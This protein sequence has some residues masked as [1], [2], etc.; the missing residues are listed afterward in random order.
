MDNLHIS[1]MVCVTKDDRSDYIFCKTKIQM[2]QTAQE[3]VKDGW[4]LQFAGE[5]KVL[6]DYTLELFQ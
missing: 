2:Q 3:F 1:F 6:K 5:V 4:D